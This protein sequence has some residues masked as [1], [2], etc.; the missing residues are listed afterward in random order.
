MSGQLSGR[1]LTKIALKAHVSVRTLYRY[2]N[3][4]QFQQLTAQRQRIAAALLAHGRADLVR[5]S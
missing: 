5:L 4:A 1:E 3:S 2:L